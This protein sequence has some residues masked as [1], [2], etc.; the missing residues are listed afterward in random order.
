MNPQREE[1][2]AIELENTPRWVAEHMIRLCDR[3]QK[4]ETELNAACEGSYQRI[5]F[6]NML[7]DRVEAIEAHLG[8]QSEEKA[9]P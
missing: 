4:L 6:L 7:L 5:S 9:K 2:A 3:I 8:R 1:I